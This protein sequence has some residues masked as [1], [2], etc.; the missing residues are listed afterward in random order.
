MTLTKTSHTS[1]RVTICNLAA[2][3]FIN[4][5]Y[6]IDINLNEN[7]NLTLKNPHKIVYMHS[8]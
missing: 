1:F 3:N 5:N 7:K 6:I 8:K 2:K 4:R